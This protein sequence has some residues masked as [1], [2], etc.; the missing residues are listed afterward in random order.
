VAEEAVAHGKGR[1][2]LVD[3]EAALVHVSQ[4]MLTYLGYEVV[5]YT[6]SME[7]LAAFK[8]APYSFDLILTDHTMPHLTGEA[9]AR[10]LRSIRPDLPII[11]CTGFS[12]TMNEAKAHALGIDALLM[13]PFLTRDLGT[14]IQQVLAQRSTP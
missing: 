9:L 3:D 7:A 5:T 12:H 1:V 11:L 8:A 13:K 14:A 4:G 2:L 10:E 6:N